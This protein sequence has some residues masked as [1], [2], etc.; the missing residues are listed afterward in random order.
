MLGAAF[1]GG[2]A[3]TSLLFGAALG[4]TGKISTRVMGLIMAFGAGTLISALAFELTDEAFSLG[5]GDAVAIGLAL[6]ALTYFAGDELISRSSETRRSRRRSGK[7][8]AAQGPKALLL[9]AVLDGIPESVVIG[10]SLLHG[11]GV[12][13]PIIAAVFLSNFPEALSSAQGMRGAGHSPL[14][15]IGVWVVVV[16]VSALAAAIG[17]GVLGGASDNTVGLIL[18]FAGGA[19]LTMLADTMMPEAFSYG[20]RATGLLTVLG[21]ATAYLLSAVS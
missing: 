4:L 21:F 18:A 1:F 15:I 11:E 7:P 12:S 10:I 5:G 6:G 20:H 14:K 19:V 8:D 13:I 2:L 17:Y 3:A 16:G 9:G